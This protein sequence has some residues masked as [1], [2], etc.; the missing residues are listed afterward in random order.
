M[1]LVSALCQKTT[2]DFTHFKKILVAT[3]VFKRNIVMQKGFERQRLAPIHTQ[4]ILKSSVSL[5]VMFLGSG[6]SYY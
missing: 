2:K 6:N 4:V 5:K 3:L 1:Q